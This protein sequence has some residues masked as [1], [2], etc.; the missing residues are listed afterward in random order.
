M[1]SK[2]DDHFRFNS[3]HN[4]GTYVSIRKAWWS[5]PSYELQRPWGKWLGLSLWIANHLILIYSHVSVLREVARSTLKHK[6][7]N[8]HILR[9]GKSCKSTIDIDF[10]FQVH[11]RCFET[12]MLECYVSSIQTKILSL[13]ICGESVHPSSFLKAF[14]DLW[15]WYKLSKYHKSKSIR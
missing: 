8:A 2:Y 15:Y 11:K 4:W 7:P 3:Q 9:I 13:C 1:C 14:W 12:H 6:S 10:K 5:S